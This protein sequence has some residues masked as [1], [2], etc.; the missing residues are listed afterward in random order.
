MVEEVLATGGGQRGGGD[1][2]DVNEREQLAAAAVAVGMEA[3]IDLGEPSEENSALL[4]AVDAT[5]TGGEERERLF[6]RLA[7]VYSGFHAYRD[8]TTRE[9]PIVRLRPQ[10]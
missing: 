8:R 2:A 3:R 6:G 1:P 4:P 7:E 10:G 9:L 5:V